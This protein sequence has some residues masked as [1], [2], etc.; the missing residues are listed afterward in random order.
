MTDKRPLCKNCGTRHG[1]AEAHAYGDRNA[2]RQTTL[3]FPET[4]TRY[5]CSRCAELEREVAALKAQLAKK[6]DTTN[7]ARQKAYRE[8][9]GSSN[10]RAAV[11]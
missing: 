2:L 4:V 6:R 9:R 5:Y 10:G 8:R 7:A 11:P 3:P 1:L